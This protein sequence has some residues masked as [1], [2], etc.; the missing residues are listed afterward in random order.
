MAIPVTMAIPVRCHTVTRC[1]VYD[2]A[3][4]QNRYIKVISVFMNTNCKIYHYEQCSNR[5]QC[6]RKKQLLCR[7][8]SPITIITKL[9][10]LHS[11]RQC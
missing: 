5:R 2:S 7:R 10:V 4:G 1:H 11:S 6:A 8:H 3:A 9:E